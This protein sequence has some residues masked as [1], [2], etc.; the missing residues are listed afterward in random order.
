M[1]K[2]MCLSPQ[3]AQSPAP[4]GPGDCRMMSRLDCGNQKQQTINK[5]YTKHVLNAKQ[6]LLD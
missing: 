6:A 1:F 2:G 5:T 3:T 4:R